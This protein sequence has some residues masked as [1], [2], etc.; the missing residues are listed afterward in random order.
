MKLPLTLAPA[1]P[2][3]Y[4]TLAQAGREAFAADKQRYG[5][6]PSI[7]EN[8]A[9]LLPLLAKNDGT[10][11]KL[12]AGETLIGV[13]ITIE[14]APGTRRLGCL[15]LPPK[16]QGRGYGAQA[17][18]LLEAMYPTA[19]TWMLDTP[20]DSE[21]N[22]HFYEK[23]GYRVVGESTPPGAPTLVLLEKQVD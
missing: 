19:K 20:A 3:D 21:R 5:I 16:W 23:A 8:P 22:R 1:T 10:V 14:T 18:Q 12:L 2:A 17:L 15:C 9:F 6:G 7:Y 11:Q 13:A 4:P